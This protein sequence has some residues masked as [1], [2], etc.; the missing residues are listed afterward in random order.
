MRKNAMHRYAVLCFVSAAALSLGLSSQPATAS[1]LKDKLAGTWMLLSN[2]NTTADGHRFEPFGQNP[3]GILTFD[4]GG[5]FSLM[6]MRAKRPQ[7]A[8]NNRMKGTPEEN[9]ATVQGTLA[10]FGTYSVSDANRTFTLHVDGSTFDN[11]EGT[12]RNYKI[13][14]L[15]EELTYTSPPSSTG[16]ASA[17]LTWKRATT[18]L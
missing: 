5:H 11:W 9:A 16:A 8:A 17:E 6:L 15:G 10:L 14:K 18:R 1:S 7:F 13:D 4:T 3:K 2:F 12:D